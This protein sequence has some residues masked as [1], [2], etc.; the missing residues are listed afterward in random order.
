MLEDM[1]MAGGTNAAAAAI[2]QQNKHQ[3]EGE[4]ADGGEAMERDEDEPPPPPLFDGASHQ[5]Q[6]QSAQTAAKRG[7][8]VASQA[9]SVAEGGF[10]IGGT[11]AESFRRLDDGRGSG[12][13]A[14]PS[15]VLLADSQMKRRHSVSV[16]DASFSF[17]DRPDEQSGDIQ[18]RND[19]RAA[20]VVAAVE[21]PIQVDDEGAPPA[22]NHG[23]QGNDGEEDEQRRHQVI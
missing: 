13:R 3:R 16:V 22:D 2:A 15:S 7:T 20:E 6:R 18:N 17:F 1:A 5:R 12:C 10:G 21:E 8:A 4:A 19:G 23:H 11:L 9:A 14:G